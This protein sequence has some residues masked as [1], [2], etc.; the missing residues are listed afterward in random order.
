MTGASFV[1]SRDQVE[2]VQVVEFVLAM[3]KK[4]VLI[5]R[6]NIW[7]HRVTLGS[8]LFP[9]ISNAI[10]YSRCWLK[11]DPS[12][13]CVGKLLFFLALFYL[14]SSCQQHFPK[15]L[16][17]FTS[18]RHNNR[19]ISSVTQRETLFSQPFNTKTYIIYHSVCSMIRCDLI[20]ELVVVRA[21]VS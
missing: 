18:F 5:L 14:A 20:L 1:R 2:R 15:I 17:R 16:D 19:C 21:Q 11:I 7:W 12:R 10:S 6:K 8:D 4:N 13:R 9:N 3:A